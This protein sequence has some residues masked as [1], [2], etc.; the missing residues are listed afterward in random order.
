MNR[1]FPASV[2]LLLLTTAVLGRLCFAE[3]TNW[4]DDKTVFANPHLTGPDGEG[5]AWFWKQRYQDL[6]VPV[7]FTVWGL[8]TDV[9]RTETPDLVGAKVKPW[10]FHSVNLGV[11]L[12]AVL[13]AF[14][15]LERLLR[16]VTEEQVAHRAAWLGAALFAI[17]PLQVEAVAWVS[18]LK[19]VLGGALAL[20]AIW[21]YLLWTDA[22]PGD[23]Q[24]PR[25][26]RRSFHYAMGTAA[27]VAAMLAKPGTVV[28]P[29]LA[30]V[31]DL[32]ILR[33]RIWRILPGLLPWFL[34]A[35]AMAVIDVRVQPAPFMDTPLW[36]RPF[37]AGHALASYLQTLFF[38]RTLSLI[39]GHP[40][41]YLRQH[42]W[43]YVAWLLP[44]TVAAAVWLWRPGR[45]WLGAGFLIFLVGLLPVLGFF[46]FDFQRFSTVADHYMYL[47]MLA[48]SLA[49]AWTVARYPTPA[50]AAIASAVVLAL[51][52]RSWRQAGYW[53][54]G[55]RL[56]LHAFETARDVPDIHNNYAMLLMRR[57]SAAVNEGRR[58]EAVK[59]FES[60]ESHMR[61]ALRVKP[62]YVQFQQ[63]YVNLLVREDRPD[64]AIRHLSRL[65]P[66]QS[67]HL[68]EQQKERY[69]PLYS[70][71]G[72][73][74]LN[75][76]DYDEAIVA[77][78]EALRHLPD[79]AAAR[80]DLLIAEAKLHSASRPGGI[81]LRGSD[82][83]P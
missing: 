82:S 54:D 8:L 65:L 68:A 7:T 21:Q 78:R 23:A 18:G 36:L 52:A 27:L 57:G 66:S 73:L 40:P 83:I 30:F 63:N 43:L 33:R 24:L 4:D 50:T 35:A 38:P 5:I 53:H 10:V 34:L 3:F 22:A 41:A 28:T 2:T 32:L 55:E 20:I 13:V 58:Q 16:R 56:Y 45:R 80:A 14:N 46:S 59:L 11:H 72:H 17:H 67:P 19:D 25:L 49:A 26:G 48:V 76:G 81:S 42:I 69:A 15:I 75:Q 64:A 71:L 6:Y 62:G 77:L 29:I 37:I 70:V 39:D 74:L 60:A 44:T 51:A 9:A 12:L 31:L 61:A 79:D 1:R 47:P